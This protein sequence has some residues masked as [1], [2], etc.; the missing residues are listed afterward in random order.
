VTLTIV[1]LIAPT[2]PSCKGVSFGMPLNV[3]MRLSKY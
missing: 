1:A 3:M 2:G